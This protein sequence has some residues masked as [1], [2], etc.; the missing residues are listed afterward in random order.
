MDADTTIS[1]SYLQLLTTGKAGTK[2]LFSGRYNEKVVKVSD[3]WR[4]QERIATRDMPPK[5][6]QR[7]VRVRG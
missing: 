4:F 3:K 1:C 7:I 2:L 6:E 5:D